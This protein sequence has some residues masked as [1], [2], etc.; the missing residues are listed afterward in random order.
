MATCLATSG[1]LEPC[2]EFVGGL[3][4]VWFGNFGL[5]NTTTGAT[6]QEIGGF[7]GATT[8]Y[9]YELKGTS[10]LTQE[11]TSSRDG[12]TTFVKQTLTLNLKGGDAATANEIKLLSYGRP[13][14]FVQDNYGN[15]VLIG[16][17][18]G[19]EVLTAIHDTGAQMGDPYGYTLTIEGQEK[20]FGPFVKG[21][22]LALP[23]G[24]LTIAPTITKG[25]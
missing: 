1:R 22:T 6:I 13:H 20:I 24:T 23:F 10:K 4:K 25:T 5:V 11:L 3:Y 2:K 15:N 9:E 7:S 12:G 8:L 21:A 19:C 17:E 16:K 14:A 18:R